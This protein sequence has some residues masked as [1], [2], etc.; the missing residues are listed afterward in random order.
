MLGVAYFKAEPTEYARIS[1]KGRVKKE[2]QGISRLVFPYMTSIELIRM[3]VVD[4]PFGIQDTSQDNQ[5]VTIQGGVL[6]RVAEPTK[7]LDL[8]DFTV[9]PA[10]KGPLSDEEQKLADNITHMVRTRV[11]MVVKG[12][13]LEKLLGMAT[14]LPQTLSEHIK[15]G[16][17]ELGLEMKLLYVVSIRP[18]PEIQKAL[19]A[20]YRERLLKNADKATYERRASAVQQERVIQENELANK[21]GL[22]EQRKKLVELQGANALQEAQ[23]KADAAK[24]EF[25]AFEGMSPDTIR[26]H[27]LLA[28]GRNAAK[29]QTLTITPELLT[30]IQHKAV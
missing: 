28:L 20:D 17:G 5:D 26:A 3:T 18:M 21:I 14:D 22:E 23:Y 1:V 30:A 27:A 11:L 7:T 25:E 12:T 4:Q 13:P 8:Y 6:Y 2:G 24:R 10:T 29:I 9:N 16:M 15:K 19:G